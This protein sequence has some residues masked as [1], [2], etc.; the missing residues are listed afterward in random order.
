MGNA[1]LMGGGYNLLRKSGKCAY[2]YI[3]GPSNATKTQV[4]PGIGFQPTAW[5][6]WSN[7]TNLS[8]F[9]SGDKLYVMADILD[10]AIG[11]YYKA[12][13]SGI[14]SGITTKSS[15]C[16]YD[17]ETG[18]VTITVNT[19]A[20]SGAMW[21]V[22]SGYKVYFLFLRDRPQT[23]EAPPSTNCLEV[24]SI[25]QPSCAIAY[26][27]KPG[28]GL[29][30]LVICSPGASLYIIDDRSIYDNYARREEILSNAI[31]YN[32]DA[33]TAVLNAPNW[34]GVGTTYYML[35]R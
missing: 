13:E 8:T 6:V 31:T 30:N 26:C 32:V 25:Y 18:A 34:G 21:N 14:Q 1:I 9:G 19:D 28:V 16:S 15:T 12:S 10:A 35:A 5:A 2:G 17:A 23:I 20:A 22:H 33:K 3:A 7:I 4:F 24:P 29:C 11:Y 27:G